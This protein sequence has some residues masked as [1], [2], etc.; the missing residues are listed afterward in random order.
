MK[1]GLMVVGI[2]VFI[3]CKFEI[4]ILKIVLVILKKCM[5]FVFLYVLSISTKMSAHNL[6]YIKN[7]SFI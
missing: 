3:S 7:R 1:F 2:T 6:G 4:P 5:H